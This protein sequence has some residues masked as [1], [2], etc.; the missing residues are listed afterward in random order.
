M[1]FEGYYQILCRNGHESS[2]DCYENPYFGEE[3]TDEFGTRYPWACWCGAKAAWWNLVDETNGSYC[4]DCNSECE[5]DV[6]GCEWC[7][8][9]RIDGYIE[10]E[11]KTQAEYCTCKDCGNTH[12]KQE[13]TY[14]I[15]VG[16]GHSID[17]PYPVQAMR[18]IK[19]SGWKP[20]P[21][22]LVGKKVPV[23]LKR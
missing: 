6:E 15:P 10:L 12:H 13:K 2:A 14:K 5:E 17:E 21:P 4:D 20:K 16:R 22:T 8:N 1:S 3:I 7:T 9:G 23:K 11:V 18:E 19:E